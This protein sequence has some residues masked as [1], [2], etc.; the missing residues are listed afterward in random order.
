MLCLIDFSF[1]FICVLLILLNSIKLPQ[2]VVE[3]DLLLCFSI[4]HNLLI[5]SGNFYTLVVRVLDVMKLYIILD[6]KGRIIKF[7]C[8]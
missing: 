4:L 6:R 2:T 8:N 7:Y 3:V 1:S 5:Y